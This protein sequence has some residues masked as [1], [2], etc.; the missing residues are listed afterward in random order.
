MRTPSIALSFCII[1]IAA[2]LLTCIPGPWEYTAES[3]PVFRGITVNAY[4][5]KDR[6]VTDLWFERLHSLGE[7]Y[8]P[9]FAFYSSALVEITGNGGNGVTTV[10][11]TP[12]KGTPMR[13][14]GP[15][16][17]IAQ[18]G[19]TYTLRAVFTWD[20]AGKQVTSVIGATTKVPEK[21]SIAKTARANAAVFSK[22]I[23][24]IPGPIGGLASLL[25]GLPPSIANTI[26]SLYTPEIAPLTGDTVA[27]LD[28]FVKNQTRISN[29]IDSLLR[30]E[31]QL[32]PY[33]NGDTVAYLGGAL[34]LTSHYFDAEYSDDVMGVL[35]T[36]RFTQDALNP[37]TRFDNIAATFGELLPSDFY[38]RGTERRLQFFAR[39][40]GQAAGAAYNL[41]DAIPVNNAYLKGGLNTLYFFGAE[42]NYAAF[43]QTYI[44]G[45]SNS[46][47]TPAHSVS[48][49]QGFFAGLAVDSF[50]MYITVPPSVTS[51]STFEARSDFCGENGWTGRDCRE[52]EPD[53]CQ[54]VLFNEMQYAYDHPDII[55]MPEQRNNCLAEA[56]AFYL[57][58]NKNITYFE[59]SVLIDKNTMEW[60]QRKADGSVITER[61]TF[62]S[63]ELE[64][65]KNDGLLRYCVRSDFGPDICLDLRNDLQRAVSGN[66][67]LREIFDYCLDN[68][69]QSSSCAWALVLYCKQNP[70]APAVLREAADAWCKEHP[71]EPVCGK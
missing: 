27:L 50:S 70:S 51:Y 71:D 5:V 64:E 7:A 54:Q 20:S 12:V 18:Q 26:I 30:G 57:T 25:Q 32:L 48:G 29:S 45:H 28:Y 66:P 37:E 13:F 65:A 59:D 68:N 17:F 15:S 8:S 6:P 52:F 1:L 35:V 40:Q 36:H 39:I 23:D 62:S 3:K 22:E 46:K 11:C 56:V 41:F 9:A 69:W 21:F 33:Y 43:I 42:K 10:A 44:E 67:K 14:A 53:Y 58:A 24:G 47:I 31:S 4:M 63:E 2:G 16:D 49:G 61:K 60:K 19:E 55:R 38:F 34:N